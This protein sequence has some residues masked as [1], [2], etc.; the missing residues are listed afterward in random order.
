VSSVSKPEGYSARRPEPLFWLIY[1]YFGRCF[2]DNRVAYCMECTVTRCCLVG[3]STHRV[4]RGGKEYVLLTSLSL[5][6]VR[7][8]IRTCTVLA[9]RTLRRA[10]HVSYRR[11][12][13][14]KRSVRSTLWTNQRKVRAYP[15]TIGVTSTRP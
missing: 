15:S 6:A 2:L 14:P 1:Y 5:V 3:V 13:R 12:S 8:R 11:R 7:V 4:A 9:S 10:Q